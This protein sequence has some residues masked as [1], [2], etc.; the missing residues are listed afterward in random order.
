MAEKGASEQRPAVPHGVGQSISRRVAFEGDDPQGVFAQEVRSAKLTGFLRGH[1]TAPKCN[2]VESVLEDF[3]AE[4]V[5]FSRCDFKDSAIRSSRFRGCHFGSSSFAYNA[6]EG[7][8]FE[9]CDFPDTDLHNCVFFDSTFLACD[10]TNVLIKSCNFAS[11]KFIDCRTSNKVFETSRFADCDFRGTEL[12]VQTLEENFGLVSSRYAGLLRDGTLG[13]VSRKYAATDLKAFLDDPLRHSLKKLNIDYFVRETLL[14]GSRFLDESVKLES[15]MPM[16]RTAGSFVVVLG[17]WVEFILGLYARDEITVHTIAC[18][19]SMTG[20]LIDLLSKEGSQSQPLSSITG[21]HMSLARA[22]ELYLYTLDQ[23]DG[24]VG[25]ELTLLVEGGNNH[26]YYYY[27]LTP[28]FERAQATIARL[29]PHN[30]PWD[31]VVSFGGSADH[32]LFIALLLATRLR[33]ELL[34]LGERQRAEQRRL[35][36]AGRGAI[37]KAS[38]EREASTKHDTVVEINLGMHRPMPENPTLRLR[39]YVPGDLVAELNL[40]VGSQVIAKIRK[41]VRDIL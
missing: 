14:E 7:S 24:A 31:L 40:D 9:E 29:A 5:D 38:G 34:R 18:L 12:Q 35:P 8:G 23:L 27:E 30:S 41:T 22:A 36:A 37:G 32:F 33:F 16:F 6:V 2:I 19:H 11:C 21:A 1:R 4:S 10:F 20:T 3:N 17:Q 25:N 13:E 26:E 39:F 28:L 15:W